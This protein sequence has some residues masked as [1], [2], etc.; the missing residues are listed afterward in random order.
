[1][2]FYIKNNITESS[3]KEVLHL[4]KKL[5]GEYFVLW[6]FPTAEEKKVTYIHN[7]L[8]DHIYKHQTKEMITTY[9]D[10]V[11][12]KQITVYKIAPKT[13]CSLKKHIRKIKNSFDSLAIYSNS[14]KWILCSTFDEKLI[15]IR[16]NPKSKA[17]VEKSNFK[18]S[19]KAPSWW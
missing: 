1:M 13:V 5:G 7:Q 12:E 3:I 18:F 16:K 11:T 4:S 6:P 9:L 2:Y 17:V 14:K 19:D 8:S 10:G 15:L